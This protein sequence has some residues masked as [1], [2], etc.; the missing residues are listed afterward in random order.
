MKLSKEQQEFWDVLHLTRKVEADGTICWL[1]NGKYH[2]EPGPAI[3][4][5][6]GAKYWYKNGSL[7]REDGPA[8]IYPNGSEY[9][10]LNG[11]QVAPF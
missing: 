6:S 11:K 9:W 10:Y 8:I 3:I 7:H 5:P 1:K 2:R 4:Y